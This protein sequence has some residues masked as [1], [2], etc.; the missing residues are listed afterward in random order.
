M[1]LT[2]I[3]LTVLMVGIF[4]SVNVAQTLKPQPPGGTKQN[5]DVPAGNAERKNV[6]DVPL[7]MPLN[8]E[9]GTPIKV[10]IDFGYFSPR[11]SSTSEPMN[12][13]EFHAS[14]FTTFLNR[15]TASAR[16]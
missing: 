12:P 5:L 7:V 6:D 11:R 4:S 13:H 8:V 16:L 14:P 1:R 2:V 9:A 15:P 3:G 10:A